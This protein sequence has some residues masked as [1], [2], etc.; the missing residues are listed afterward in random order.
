MQTSPPAGRR[1]DDPAIE[2][3]LYVLLN[4]Y[5]EPLEFELPENP[6]GRRWAWPIDTLLVECSVTPGN[7]EA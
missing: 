1:A 7:D 6:E 5:W 2:E 3:H 4:A